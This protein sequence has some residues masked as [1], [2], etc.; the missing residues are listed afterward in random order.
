[1]RER[2]AAFV[3]VL[4]LLFCAMLSGCVAEHTDS[5]WS[6]GIDGHDGIFT[7]EGSYYT[8][9]S[10]YLHFLD[11]NNGVNVCLCSKVCSFMLIY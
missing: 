10:G 5:G 8:D 7:G 4:V 9:F 11:V 2:M 3:L 6:E 1:M